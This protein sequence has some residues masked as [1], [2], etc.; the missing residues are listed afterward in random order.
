MTV[1]ATRPVTRWVQTVAATVA[2]A[3]TLVTVS[4]DDLPWWLLVSFALVIYGLRYGWQRLQ[5]DE[6]GVTIR[7]RPGREQV[8]WHEI[9]RLEVRWL[10]L[11]EGGSIELRSAHPLI[12][13]NDGR[14][15]R[16]P[17][18]TDLADDRRSD[19]RQALRELL[20]RRA[21]EHGFEL[22]IHGPGGEDTRTDEHVA[23][24]RRQR[25]SSRRPACGSCAH[26]RS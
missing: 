17:V 2:V 14:R 18:L 4:P 5:L 25:G 10:R 21:D 9:D 11:R 19:E 23:R 7:R 15:V 16:S 20:E 3:T 13:R 8:A 26:Q 22:V 6:H 1:D 24:R 12:E